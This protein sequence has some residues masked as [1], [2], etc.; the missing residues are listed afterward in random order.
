M[1]LLFRC[2]NH[3]HEEGQSPQSWNKAVISIIRKEGKDKG[4]YSS[5]TAISI[6][7]MDYKLFASI[8]TE[9]IEHTVSE[10]IYPD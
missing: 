8:M 3:T 7:N 2:F 1:P 6:L 4:E 5:Y 9:K 10:M